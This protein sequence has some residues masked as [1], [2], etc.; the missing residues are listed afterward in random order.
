MSCEILHCHYLELGGLK[1]AGKHTKNMSDII[2]SQKY[3]TKSKI[4]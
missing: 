3:E 2:R 1:L 4:Y